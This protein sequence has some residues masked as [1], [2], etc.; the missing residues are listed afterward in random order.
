MTENTF[1]QNQT[2]FIAEEPILEQPRRDLKPP[3][4]VIAEPPKKRPA[5]VWWLVGAVV[6]LVIIGVAFA[7]QT[8]QPENILENTPSPTPVQ[9]VLS[10]LEQRLETIKTLLKAAD[11]TNQPLPFPPIDGEL[12]IDPKR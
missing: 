8:Q 2:Q 6:L 11:P 3:E 9:R 7:L 4:A 12:R 1:N 5:W 10:P